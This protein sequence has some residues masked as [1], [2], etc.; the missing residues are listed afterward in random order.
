MTTL[1]GAIA[2]LRAM[3]GARLTAR[4][5]IRVGAVELARRAGSQRS[6]LILVV[7]AMRTTELTSTARHRCDLRKVLAESQSTCQALMVKVR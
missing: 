2:A 1:L 7:A 4:V 5:A 3:R 6:T